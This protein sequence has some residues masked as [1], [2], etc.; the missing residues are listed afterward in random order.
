MRSL[1]RNAERPAVA[2][3]LLL[4]L[5][6]CQAP[7]SPAPVFHVVDASIA[8]IHAAMEAG[9]LTARQL[10]EAYLARIEAY[11]KH[12]PAL[13]AIV[14]INPNALA[15][16]RTGR[17]LGGVGPDRPAPRHPRHRQGQLRHVRFADQRR[18]LVTGRVDATG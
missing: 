16:R 15:R 17:G 8:D 6:G 13:N 10:V 18:L 9:A 11:D 12:G 3:G 2:F 1:I 5:S 7:P 14:T 4:A